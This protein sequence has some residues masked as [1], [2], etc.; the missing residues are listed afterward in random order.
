[1]VAT[2]DTYRI[3]DVLGEGSYGKVYLG[4]S[5][6][7]GQQVA[8]KTNNVKNEI[9]VLQN[10]AHRNIVKLLDVVPLA[11][12]NLMVMELA[13]GGD[14]LEDVLNGCLPETEAARLFAEIV[15]AVEHC[16]QKKFL[17]GDLKP[18]NVL[19]TE[20]R[21]VRLAD[22]GLAV[23]FD[24][25]TP[26][27][28]RPGTL[29][30]APPESFTEMKVYG[31]A[32]DVWSLGVLLYVI[33]A[34][35]YPF[36]GK[37]NEEIKHAILWNNPRPLSPANTSKELRNLIDKILQKNSEERISLAEICS[38][39]WLVRAVNEARKHYEALENGSMM[40]DAPFQLRD[41]WLEKLQNS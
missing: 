19:L 20:L 37:D 22:F 17:H 29:L 40:E 38:H 21:R 24:P 31:P 1:M 23:S 26:I 34:G 41:I 8:I 14:L 9:S 10:L 35:R 25:A 13:S 6:K 30:Y 32:T 16:H 15:L 2:N 5:S 11:D 7:N 33:V 18:E 12:G 27:T 4:T 3:D 28:V 36:P 39:P